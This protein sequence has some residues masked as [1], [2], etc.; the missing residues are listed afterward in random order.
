[1]T[2][3]RV[4]ALTATPGTKADAVQQVLTNCYVSKVEVRTEQDEDVKTYLPHKEICKEVVPANPE[5]AVVCG[6]LRELVLPVI[7]RLVYKKVT[8]LALTSRS[9]L[10]T[11]TLSCIL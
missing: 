4:L 3:F 11:Q 7:Q 5:L 2:G 8:P 1:M 10:T 6:L 9:K